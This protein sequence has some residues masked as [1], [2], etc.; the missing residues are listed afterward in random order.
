[1][2]F[3]LIVKMINSHTEFGPPVLEP[4][5]SQYSQSTF[6]HPVN[7]LSIPDNYLSSLQDDLVGGGLAIEQN[8]YSCS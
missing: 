1:M 7:Q 5:T 6:H 3:I 8:H 2:Y 4:A